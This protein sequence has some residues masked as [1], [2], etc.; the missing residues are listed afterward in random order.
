MEF[1][2][3][4]AHLD[5]ERFD[6]DREEILE[7]IKMSGV[8]RLISAGYSLESSKKAVELST[9]V[10]SSFLI[11]ALANPPSTNVLAMSKKIA[12][13]AIAPKSFGE[14]SRAIIRLMTKFTPCTEK[15]S[16]ALHKTALTDFSFNDDIF[17]VHHKLD[18]Y[19]TDFFFNCIRDA[20]T[21]S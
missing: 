12:N 5:D 17:F 3:S 7:K 4:H 13:M 10:R 19:S 11:S 14:T 16:T 6:E 20:N 8:T 9:S 2:D 1:F 18:I 15:R 21:S